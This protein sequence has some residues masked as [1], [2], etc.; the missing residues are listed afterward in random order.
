M[1][2]DINILAPNMADTFNGLRVHTNV[3]MTESKTVYPKERFVEYGSEDDWWLSYFKQPKIIQ[4]PSR[5]AFRIGDAIIMH[6]AVWDEMKTEL[7]RRNENYEKLLSGPV[8]DSVK[9]YL[10]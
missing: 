7:R 2:I 8:M 3:L 9:N 1:P 5:K 6:P 4:V 10:A